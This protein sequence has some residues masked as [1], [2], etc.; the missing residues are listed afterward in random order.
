[1]YLVSVKISGADVAKEIGS[2]AIFVPT[3][4]T[5]EEQVCFTAPIREVVTPRQSKAFETLRLR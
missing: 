3:D 2:K 4:V 5:S 1:M